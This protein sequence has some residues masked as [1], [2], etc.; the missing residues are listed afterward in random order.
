MI[1]VILRGC[2]CS[3]IRLLLCR[4][5]L[6]IVDSQELFAFSGRVCGA[7]LP[8]MLNNG[9]HYLHGLGALRA[10]VPTAPRSFVTSAPD[11]NSTA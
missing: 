6:A 10:A 5:Q 3:I 7:L 4:F 1:F 8:K 11:T 2:L 9:L